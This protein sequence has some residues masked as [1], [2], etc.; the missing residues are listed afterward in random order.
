M[1]E[2]FLFPLDLKNTY[3]EVDL[4]LRNMTYTLNDDQ[5]WQRNWP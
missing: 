5:F 1:K 2:D 3:T 4:F